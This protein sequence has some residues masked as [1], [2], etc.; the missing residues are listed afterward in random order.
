MCPARDA[1]ASCFDADNRT[2]YV[3]GGYVNGDK[4]N[5]LWKYDIVLEKWKCLHK[6]DYRL[7]PSKQNPKE[8]PTSRVGAR[9]IMVDERTLMVHNGHD[10]SNEKLQDI[11]TFDIASAKWSEVK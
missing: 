4:S 3:F 11:W 8:V 2:F 9:M 10:A 6:G 1:H 7:D 5:D